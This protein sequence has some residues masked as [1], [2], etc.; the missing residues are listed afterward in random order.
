[1]TMSELEKVTEQEN[2]AIKQGRCPDCGGQLYIT[3][4]G[5]LALNVACDCGAKFWVA[6][7]FTPERI[8]KGIS[9]AQI[10]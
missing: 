7:P 8:A 1:M 5:G 4:R 3:A 9:Y 10:E 2:E 6:Y